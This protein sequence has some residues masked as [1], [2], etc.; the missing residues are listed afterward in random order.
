MVQAGQRRLL[1]ESQLMAT[2]TTSDIANIGTAS[3]T[4]LSP[5]T[6][7]NGMRFAMRPLPLRSK[8]NPG[9]GTGAVTG[10]GISLWTDLHRDLTYGAVVT[11]TATS[12][13]GS[14]FSG[15]GSVSGNTCTVTMTA[16]KN[17]HCCLYLKPAH[18]DCNRHRNRFGLTAPGLS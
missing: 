12:A 16:N 1:P 13:T 8:K 2:I 4:V 15:C 7:S 11:F 17:R 5:C 18:P 10:K 3:V 14:T 6:F 9:T